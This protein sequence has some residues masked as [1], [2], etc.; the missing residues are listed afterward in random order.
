MRGLHE[1]SELE[2]EAVMKAVLFGVAGFVAFTVA[3]VWYFLRPGFNKA[4]GVS[5]LKGALCQDPVFWT[6][7]VTAA[8][9]CAS[10]YLLIRR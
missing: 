5:A 1:L 3:W 4:T 7:G 2:E 6:L 9:G 8:F 10:L